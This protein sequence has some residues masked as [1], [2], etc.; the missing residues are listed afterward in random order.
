MIF[1]LGLVPAENDSEPQPD[2]QWGLG[3]IFTKRAE[4]NYGPWAD[5]QRYFHKKTVCFFAFSNKMATQNTGMF[6]KK[7]TPFSRTFPTSGD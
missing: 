3:V 2:P 7:Y 5:Q 4:I 6:I 1:C